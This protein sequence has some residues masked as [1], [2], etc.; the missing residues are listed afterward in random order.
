[1][2]ATDITYATE[3][4]IFTPQTPPLFSSPSYQTI[5]NTEMEWEDTDATFQTRWS[6]AG[7]E[8]V[9]PQFTDRKIDENEKVL[10]Y[11]LLPGMLAMPGQLP[12]SAQAPMVQGTPQVGG[13]PSVQGTPAAPG[14]APLSIQ[15]QGFNHGAG[16]SAPSSA[17]E[18]PQSPPIH[19]LNHQPVQHV[20]YESPPHHYQPVHHPLPN[21]PPHEL[22]HHHTGQLRGHRPHTSSLQGSAAVTSKAG[23][24]AAF[25]WL[26]IV[27]VSVVVIATSGIIVVLAN[28]PGLSLSGSNA[29]AVGQVL[30]LHGKGFLPG[31]G[32][33]LSLDNGSPVSFASLQ[34]PQLSSQA[35][36]RNANFADVS[37]MLSS[38]QFAQQSTVDAHVSIGPTGNFDAD[39]LVPQNWSPGVHTIHATESLGSRS[40][41]LQFTILS[42]QLVVNPKKLDFG[43]L[44]VGNKA[45]LPVAVG[46]TGQERLNWT[47]NIDSSGTK[48][49]KI[50]GSA[51]GAITFRGSNEII[52]VLADATGLKVGH[53]TT[54]LII[55]SDDGN[56]QIPV[57]L[58]VIPKSEKQ[59]AQLNVAPQSLDLGQIPANQQALQ[60]IAVGNLG[61]LPLK[62]QAATDAS[63]ASWLTLSMTSGTIQAGTLP[64]TIMV[65]INTKTLVPGN[66]SGTISIT[67]NGG[68]SQI[69]VKLNVLPSH[70]GNPSLPLL[71]ASP[72]GFNVPG[73]PN[74]TYNA[75]IGW[76]CTAT[77]SSFATAQSSLGWSANSNGVSGITFTPKSGTLLAGQSVPVTISIPNSVCPANATFTFTGPGNQVVVP[78]SCGSLTLTANKASLNGNT[79][80]TFN[81]GWTCSITLSTGSKEQG[82]L[83]WSVSSTGINGISFSQ[84]KGVLTAGQSIPI[85]ITI[86]NATCPASASFSFSGQHANTV[87]VPWSCS[88]P[89]LVVSK[90][91]LNANTDCTF[92]NGWSCSE[93]LSLSSSNPGD[94]SLHWSAS[95]SGSGIS[96]NPSSGTLSPGQPVQVTITIPNTT[97]P[98]NANFKFSGQGSNSVSVSWSCIPPKL[99][100]S[101]S[102]FN[103]NTDCTFDNSEHT[104]TCTAMVSSSQSAQTNLDWSTS[105][106][107]FSSNDAFNVSF[108]PA[109]G[110]LTPGQSMQ[111][112]ISIASS[113]QT[114]CPANQF[115]GT[116]TFTGPGNTV[117]VPWNCTQPV[118]VAS[119]TSLTGNNCSYAADI[120]WTCTVKVS[121]QSQGFLN[122]SAKSS[123]IKGITFKPGT[124]AFALP[125]ASTQVIITIP[126][127][128]CP[129]SATLTFIGTANTVNVSWTCAPPTITANG[130][131]DCPQ[132]E[133]YNYICT[134]TL[135]LAQ[136]SQGDLPWS[137][138][139]DLPNVTFSPSGGTLVPG[140]PQRVTV[141]VPSSDC[142]TGHFLYAGHGSNTA[143][144]SWTCNSSSSYSSS[145]L[146][147]GNS[148]SY[149]SVLW[150]R[151]SNFQ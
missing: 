59:Q 84:A 40:A 120:G 48:W 87:T 58:T 144:V 130:G 125:G 23:M 50:Q 5:Q 77:L 121:Q 94:P 127:A 67:S 38:E 82:Q 15:G 123:G 30:H 149:Y 45:A 76:T 140:Q 136:G 117:N 81:N 99:N 19:H 90:N 28:S 60:S 29:V 33:T 2:T 151:E 43:S 10:P 46:N 150:R 54:T 11:L 112:T 72:G 102:S 42:S 9:N 4:D 146:N 12:S 52:N 65:L 85:T 31:A 145:G 79:D 96:F 73:D 97:C 61:E 8:S 34:T 56:A 70:G 17:P 143:T 111:V 142:T 93:T 7:M 88:P 63:S 22:E 114:S 137:A 41:S 20:R 75:E 115:T 53:Y 126:D 129:A 66:Y 113:S 91:S 80:C 55:H 147:N 86:P 122:W 18:V 6:A 148:V 89:M 83:S 128:V 62:W 131:G 35:E 134:D 101:P 16:S 118:L 108:K 71:T 32:V 49:L 141:T 57:S 103:A 92:D 25:K 27:L 68:N 109:N 95:A 100:V 39:I 74:C 105:S 78:W 98:A 21:P 47:A 44:Q 26:I 37:L 135:A 107:G 3:T 116:L 138:T 106:N 14:N 1:M 110:T 119:P 24:S 36:G 124:G 104:W 132:D 139:S 51:S 69:P 133:N 13:V 64:Q